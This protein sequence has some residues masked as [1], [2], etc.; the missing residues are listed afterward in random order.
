M[1]VTKPPQTIKAGDQAVA[2]ESESD[3]ILSGTEGSVTY[4]F[5]ETNDVLKLVW[6]NPFFG[7]NHYRVE[8]IPTEFSCPYEGGD[9]DNARVTFSLKKKA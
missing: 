7:S 5:D 3:G 6:V 4:K 9:G 2:W 8:E 1:W